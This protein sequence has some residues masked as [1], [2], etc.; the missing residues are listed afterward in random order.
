MLRAILNEAIVTLAKPAQ[1]DAV[2]IGEAFIFNHRHESFHALT[3][4]RLAM[5]PAE[6]EL[7]RVLGKMLA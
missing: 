3:I 7:I 4:G 2:P 5:I 1:S 6:G